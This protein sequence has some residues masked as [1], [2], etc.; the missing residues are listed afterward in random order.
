MLSGLLQPA[1]VT[2]P[3]VARPCLQQAGAVHALQALLVGLYDIPWTK[4]LHSAAFDAPDLP[5]CLPAHAHVRPLSCP[6]QWG[7]GG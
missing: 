2:G 1:A 7:N 5:A 3:K 6:V 4:H